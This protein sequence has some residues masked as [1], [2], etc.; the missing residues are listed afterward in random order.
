MDLTTLGKEPISPESPAGADARYEP[1]FEALQAEVDKMSSP[2]ATGGVDWARVRDLSAEVLSTL[3]KDILAAGYLAVALTQVDGID[4]FERGLRV[5]GDLVETHWDTLFPAKARMRGRIAAVEWWV[6]KSESVLAPLRGAELPDERIG[7]MRDDIDRIDRFLSAN[8]DESPS[9]RPLWDFAD[10][11]VSAAPPPAPEP[12]PPAPEPAREPAPQTFAPP[13]APPAAPRAESPSH[14]VVFPV[15]AEPLPEVGS[16]DEAV[17]AL[18]PLLGRIGEAAELLREAGLSSP[19]HYRLSRIAAWTAIEGVPAARNGRTDFPPPASTATF[20]LKGF[21]DRGEDEAF[22]AVA[23]GMTAQCPFWLDLQYRIHSALERLGPDFEA[24]ATAVRC[25]T[26]S[27]AA[28]MPGLAELSFT[29]GSPMA[30]EEAKSWLARIVSGGGAPSGAPAEEPTAKALREAKLLAAEGRLAEGAR[31]LQRNAGSGSGRERLE[32][33][34]ALCALLLDKDPSGAVVPLLDAVVEAIDRHGLDA[35]D[36]ALA[37]K[38][39][40]LAYAGYRAF[41]DR[42][43]EEKVAA[44]RGRLSRID[45]AAALEIE[46][47]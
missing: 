5:M 33:Q 43:P 7:A 19:L 35:F 10:S 30:G 14:P 37:S 27:F 38:G 2:T 47:G 45:L 11:L 42:V 15:V 44:A 39:L 1:A 4:G 6:S 32:W 26:A 20:M 22:V 12:P 46:N 21:E 8:V 23:E 16:A 25:E 18:E 36:P 31:R 24:A 28:R 34:M 3:S 13:A 40:R 9:L 17:A 41:A 29:D